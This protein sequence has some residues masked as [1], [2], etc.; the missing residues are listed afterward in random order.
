MIRKKLFFY[1]R[2]RTFPTRLDITTSFLMTEI[3]SHENFPFRKSFCEEINRF[4]IRI[5]PTVEGRKFLD[6]CLPTLLLYEGWEDENV[7]VFI[8]ALELVREHWKLFYYF[9]GSL[10]IKTTGSHFRKLREGKSKKA[11]TFNLHFLFSRGMN[12]CLH[13][14]EGTNKARLSKHK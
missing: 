3:F 11:L 9:A 14:L 13:F 10:D 8:L 2:E 5:L 12:F 4:S 6:I 1:V 7:F